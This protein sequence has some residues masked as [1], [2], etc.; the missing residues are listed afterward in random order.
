MTQQNIGIKTSKRSG[1]MTG[2]GQRR[3]AELLTLLPSRGHGGRKTSAGQPPIVPSPGPFEK[4]SLSVFRANRAAI[5]NQLP[6]TT[7]TTNPLMS[8]G[9][10]KRVIA[11]TM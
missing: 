9:F 10:A 3:Q 4:A 11:N 7:I 5:L 1:L 8:A 2:R 6:T